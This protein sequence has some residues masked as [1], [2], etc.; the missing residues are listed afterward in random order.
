MNK[1]I[2]RTGREKS[3]LRHHPW[4]FSG[5]VEYIDG[6]PVA[7][8]TVEVVSS[9]E[10]FLAHA[11]YSPDSQIVARV[12]NWRRERHIYPK[13]FHG[14]LS[15]AV[16][17]RRTLV[18]ESNAMRLVHGESDGLPG[19]VVDIYDDSVIMQVLSAGMERWYQTCADIL[20]ELTGAVRVF[21]RSDAEVRQ[22]EGL[23]PRVGVL[24]G[25]A[26]AQHIK[27]KEGQLGF[28]V[29]VKS[30]QKTGFYLDQRVNRARVGS[31]AKDK[32]VLDCFCHSG[33]FALHALAND[34][35]SVL[36]V[37]TS[38]T[39]LQ[40]AQESL[41]LNNLPGP[42]AAWREGD[43]F[44]VLRDLRNKAKHFD[45]IILDPPK[46]APTAA[47]A[48]KAARAYKDIN[49]LAFKLLR[50]GG[51]LAT[52]SCSGGISAEL[53][54]KIVAGAALDAGVEAQIIEFFAAAPDHP[55]A[56][57]FPESA[58]LKGLLCRISC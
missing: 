3:L 38:E 50:P 13:F 31:I 9:Q 23:P 47:F 14:R 44:E 43:V 57:N 2:L 45:L 53:F 37:D 16:E 20:L 21:E 52:F 24:R 35:K 34:A 39:A 6:K 22:L 58:Y 48:A 30:G 33:G 28:W 19:L 40:L 5:A 4:I 1:L 29:D 27:I 7:G 26:P 41:A 15:H 18:H 11:A 8:D 55:V 42:R 36:S 46:F 51:L 25:S 54:Q 12:W 49:L 10:E 17:A 56:L 32:D